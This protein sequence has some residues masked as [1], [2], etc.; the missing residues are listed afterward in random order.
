MTIAAPTSTTTDEEEQPQGELALR[1]LAMPADTNVNGDI[2]GGWLVSQMDLAGEITAHRLAKKRAVTVAIDGFV[3]KHSV[4]VG[5]IVC[6]YVNVIKIGRTS[7]TM[8]IQAWISRIDMDKRVKVTEAQFTF[9]AIDAEGK[10]SPVQP[11]K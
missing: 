5:D 11:V 10:P 2:F 9:V 3:F 6:V 4:R 8:N 7:I 1:T